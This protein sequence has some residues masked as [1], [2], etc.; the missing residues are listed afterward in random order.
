MHHILISPLRFFNRP[1]A[2]RTGF[3]YRPGTSLDS[4]SPVF[5]GLRPISSPVFS[6]ASPPINRGPCTEQGRSLHRRRHRS[7]NFLRLR[8]E[9]EFLLSRSL[10]FIPFLAGVYPPCRFSSLRRPHYPCLLF[11]PSLVYLPHPNKPRALVS[12][13]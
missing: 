6:Q 4:I 11:I 2:Q 10:A 7:L 5:T 9:Q 1:S 12:F 8:P 13:P 3:S